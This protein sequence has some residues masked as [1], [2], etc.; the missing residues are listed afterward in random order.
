MDPFVT[1]GAAAARTLLKLWLRDDD[2]AAFGGSLTDLIAAKIDD[3]RTRRR[4]QHLF[5]EIEEMMAERVET[6]LTG[7]FDDVPANERAAAVLAVGAALDAARLTGIDLFAADLDPRLLERRVRDA[8]PPAPHRTPLRPEPDRPGEP[9][10]TRDLAPAARA[11]YDQVLSACCAYIIELARELPGFQTEAYASILAR[12]TETLGLLKDLLDRVPT[13]DAVP[14]TADRASARFLFDYRQ[15]TVN[16]LDRLELF[17]VTVSEPLRRYPL[18]TAYLSLTVASDSL[19]ERL[20]DLRARRAGEDTR[21]F[22][23]SGARMLPLGDLRCDT[24]LLAAS[25]LFLRGQAGAGKTTLLQWMAVRAALRDFPDEL[26][27][28]NDAVPFLIKLRRYVNG[29]FPRPEEFITEVAENYAAELPT[30]WV[31]DQLRSGSALVLID[32]I[33]E[34][35]ES[36]RRAARTWLSRL[37]G[38]FPD[39]RYVVTSRPAAVAESWLKCD[40]FDAAELQPMTPDDIRRFVRRWHDAYDAGPEPERY[41]AALVETIES[42]SHLRELAATPLLCAM[43]CALNADRRMHL[44]RDRMELY[45]SALAMLFGR[46]DEERDI[47]AEPI[48]MSPRE[49]TLI[50]QGLAYWLVH[51]G[52]GDAERTDAEARVGEALRTIPRL[53][54]A[55][56]G[57]VLTQLLVRGGVLREPLTGRVDFMHRTFQEYL[58]AK[59]AVEGG[60]IGALINHA[61]DDQWFQVVV[62]AA[63]H[64]QPRQR[65]DLLRGLLDR[66]RSASADVRHKLHLVAVTCLE[67][68]VPLAPDLHAEIRDLAKALVPPSTISA[69]TALAKA[70]DFAL[71]LLAD[72]RPGS[73]RASVATIRCARM[74]GGDAALPVIAR[75]GR[76]S[77]E[78]VADELTAAWAYFDADEY[79]RRVLSGSAVCQC[80]LTVAN[81]AQQ[82]ALRRVRGLRWVDV[83]VFEGCGDLGFVASN[84]ELSSLRVFT[85]LRMTDIGHLAGHPGLTH[86]ELVEVGPLDLAPLLEIPGLNNLTVSLGR[87]RTVDSLRRCRQLYALSLLD[88]P[89]DLCL[90]A[91]LPESTT[92]SKLELSGF[93]GPLRM[94][95]LSDAESLAKATSFELTCCSTLTS[96]AGIEAWGENVEELRLHENHRLSDL[97]AL[98]SLTNLRQIEIS[99]CPSVSDL[100]ALCELTALQWAQLDMLDT[101]PIDLSVMKSRNLRAL[102]LLGSG[103]I[104]LRPLAGYEGL[105]VYVDTSQRVVGAEGLGAGSKVIR[106][107]PGRP[108][109]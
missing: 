73:I 108:L 103:D 84:P 99:H 92:L 71:D 29:A 47:A 62:L 80:P 13:P 28:W 61:D 6:L 8:R 41:E 38:D 51:N 53:H 34:L 81:A 18:T 91:V 83:D 23:R 33:D 45:D 2:I 52:R 60:N 12:L 74:I 44:P 98:R 37:V 24:V 10:Q 67:T 46:R 86:V 30:G 56:P 31:Q 54:D 22:G 55:E 78:K 25:R 95:M 66:A 11:L 93:H 76:H 77:S 69:A 27:A 4:T 102:S 100:S 15:A 14:A 36:R 58:A 39:A 40:D 1:L 19:R 65:A 5:E 43:L 59:A 32:G 88:I 35:P 87:A 109:R 75:A 7:E 64:A 42:R 68:A 9:D 16:R 63:G 57:D 94:S 82:T 17:G 90:N 79:A 85:D 106:S 49:K 26:A 70:G 101:G 72:A 105:K 50:L 20:S 48:A 3:R 96:L 107:R 89:S 104:D 21:A 97:D